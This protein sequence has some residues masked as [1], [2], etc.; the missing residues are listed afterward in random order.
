LFSNWRANFPNKRRVSFSV[1]SPTSTFSKRA[2]I[3]EITERMGLKITQAKVPLNEM[4]GYAT[5]LRSLTQGRGTFT[6]EFSHFEEVPENIQREI[7][8]GRKK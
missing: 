6:M 8:E 4:F 3:E 5:V 7:I 1:I 2:K